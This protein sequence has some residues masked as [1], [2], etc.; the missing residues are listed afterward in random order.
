MGPAS[1][2]RSTRQIG[3]SLPDVVVF[4]AIHAEIIDCILRMRKSFAAYREVNMGAIRRRAVR[5]AREWVS[6]GVFSGA[7]Q[8]R[9][10]LFGY[11]GYSFISV[12]LPSTMLFEV[13]WR[14]P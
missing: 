1:A 2:A 7:C 4:A 5:S 11:F 13:P 10:P 8:A 3:Q 9:P 6:M 12:I 14:L